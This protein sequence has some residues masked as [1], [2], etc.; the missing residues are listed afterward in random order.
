[1][2]YSEDKIIVLQEEIKD[3]KSKMEIFNENMNKIM[4]LLESKLLTN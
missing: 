1:M 4:D 3:I 2:N